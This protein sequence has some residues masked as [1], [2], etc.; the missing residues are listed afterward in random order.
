M[1]Q[2]SVILKV[3]CTYASLLRRVSYHISVC[4]AAGYIYGTETIR[5]FVAVT[6]PAQGYLNAVVFV[7]TN[8][9]AR[10]WICCSTNSRLPSVD[11]EALGC[12]R[13]FSEDSKAHSSITNVCSSQ[14]YTGSDESFL[15]TSAGALKHE[16]ARVESEEVEKFYQKESIGSYHDAL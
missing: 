5:Y 6:T 8:S 16:L 12:Y 1:N 2:A 15:S 4:A 14:T 10:E 7:L 11:E 13:E 9:K 3:R